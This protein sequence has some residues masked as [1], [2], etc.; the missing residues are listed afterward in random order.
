MVLNELIE[1]IAESLD[2]LGIEYMVIGG[3]RKFDGFV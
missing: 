3:Q 1:N 2:N